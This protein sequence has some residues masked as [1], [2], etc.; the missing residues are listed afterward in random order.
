MPVDTP[1]WIVRSRDVA[2]LAHD[3]SDPLRAIGVVVDQGSRSI[4][5]VTTAAD[6]ADAC[7]DALHVAVFTPNMQVYSRTPARVLC[8]RERVDDVRDAVSS[9]FSPHL[10]DVVEGDPHNVVEDVLDALVGVISGRAQPSSGEIV[11]PDDWRHL[12]DQC[13][14]YR[15]A[16]PWTR[17]TLGDQ[18]TVIVDV[19]QNPASFL[20]VVI[21]ADGTRRG[22][23]LY[24]TD[25]APAGQLDHD[26]DGAPPPDG[27]LMF[28]LDADGESPIEFRNKA[29]RYGWPDVADAPVWIKSMPGQLGDVSR[30]D[31]HHL[32][33]ALAGVLEHDRPRLPAADRAGTTSGVLALA[34]DLAGS[35]T[36][37]RILDT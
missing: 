23:L 31:V 15:A 29:V 10:P 24:P 16:E 13:V 22:V 36:V 8:P 6:E 33:L 14:A 26:L 19:D 5:G 37:S 28:Y 21:G 32:T 4:V 3:D 20:A 11:S 1:T 25:A 27:T 35:F 12:V 30:T 17:W 18:L 7:V 34:N 2:H 9:L